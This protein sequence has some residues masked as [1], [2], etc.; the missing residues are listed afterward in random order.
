MRIGNRDFDLKSHTY[1]MG[2]LNVTPDSFSDGG[3]ICGVEDALFFTQ[4]MIDDGADI[5]DIGGESTR[6]G[7][8]PVDARSEADRVIPVIEALRKRFD[9]PLSIDTYK[10]EVA[11]A[12]IDAGI[13]M[14][15]DIWGLKSDPDM[16]SVIGRSGLPVCIMHNR[17]SLEYD[18]F[19]T[20]V[21]IDLKESVDIGLRAGISRDRIILDPG[22]GFA[23]SYEQC[24][25]VMADLARIKAMGYPVLLGTSRKSVIGRTLELEVDDRL[26]GT[27]ATAAWGYMHGVSILRVHDVKEHARLIK[28]LEAISSYED[29]APAVHTAYLSIGSNM[30]DR[31]G[32]IRRALELLDEDGSIKVVKSSSVS[33]TEPYGGIEQERF[34]NCAVRLATS[35]SPEALL[36]RINKI[37]LLCDR[38]RD[39]RWGPR[40]LDLDIILYDDLVVDTDK[41][42]IPHGDME[43]RLFVLEPMCEIAPDVIHPLYKRTMRELLEN[44]KKL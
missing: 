7:A 10:P 9:V 5:I 21:I 20:D 39:I 4:K 38:V 31:M 19:M 37:E 22:V 13:D 2:I 18:D 32:Y 1:I 11:K 24:L 43:R 23:K 35:Y 30:G 29:P 36:D 16:A 6:P 44:L 12:A 27:L 25:Q 17:K 28:M 26:E 14:I 3:H 33:E 15:N 8:E 41:L 40:T 42:T 34:L